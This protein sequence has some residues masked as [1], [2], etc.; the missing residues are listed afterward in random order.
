MKEVYMW[1]RLLSLILDV[2]TKSQKNI[3]FTKVRYTNSD[4][5]NVCLLST[6]KSLI[7]KAVAR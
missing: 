5:L 2:N 3:R 4:L 6:H 7:M 1:M